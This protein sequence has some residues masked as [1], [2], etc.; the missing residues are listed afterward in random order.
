MGDGPSR[1]QQLVARLTAVP[2]GV[3]AAG[4]IESAPS[5]AALEG[6][7]VLVSGR[8]ARAAD[9]GAAGAYTTGRARPSLRNAIAH[10]IECPG[11]RLTAGKTE[12]GTVR[13]SAAE[14]PGGVRVWVED[15]GRGLDVSR[16]LESVRGTAL[17]GGDAS[18]L[19]FLPGVS[20]RQS[21][22][23]WP[24]AAWASMLCA[25]SCVYL[26]TMPSSTLRR[27]CARA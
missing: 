7:S 23:R 27:V 21:R 15:D 25:G 1:V 13:I 8:A 26:G 5:W 19:V 17:E 18:E 12:Q 24:A 22:M 6:N 20:T 3:A 14:A 10:G 11:D 2:L 4:V 16:V 9:P